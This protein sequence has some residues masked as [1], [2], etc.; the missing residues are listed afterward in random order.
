MHAE[1]WFQEA[2]RIRQEADAIE[3]RSKSFEIQPVFELQEKLVMAGAT[4]KNHGE[5]T[6]VRLEAGAAAVGGDVGRLVV[7][8]G[9]PP[10]A[11]RRGQLSG[12]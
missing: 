6:I 5:R 12:A 3:P 1:T 2:K 7:E 11:R 4:F 9:R 10:A 8:R